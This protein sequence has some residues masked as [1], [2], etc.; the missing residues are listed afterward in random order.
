MCV[1]VYG[2]MGMCV[3]R[4]CVR[5][6]VCAC[7]CVFV[8]CLEVLNPDMLRKMLKMAFQPAGV[9]R[10]IE[11]MM[12]KMPEELQHPFE[13]FLVFI[14]ELDENDLGA[15]VSDFAA[16]VKQFKTKIPKKLAEMADQAAKKGE[17]IRESASESVSGS[18][19]GTHEV[20]MAVMVSGS[21]LG[22]TPAP[23]LSIPD[24][25]FPGDFLTSVDPMD[26][27]SMLGDN[28]PPPFDMAFAKALEVA[29]F[30]PLLPMIDAI[31]D[32]NLEEGQM[33]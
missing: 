29:R 21:K 30:A 18:S 32:G 12:A 19:F 33:D 13:D 20:E 2:C 23:S 22:T 25:K 7:M 10:A 15:I 4:V 8:S 31:K 9:Q 28:V 1:C 17:S 6:C 11:K 14:H 5:A 3:T 27:L 16:L 24:F 26:I